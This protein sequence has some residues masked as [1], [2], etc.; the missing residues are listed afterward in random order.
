MTRLGRCILCDDQ[1]DPDQVYDV[2]LDSIR[3]TVTLDESSEQQLVQDTQARF[4][5]VQVFQAVTRSY[6]NTEVIGHVEQSEPLTMTVD[7]RQYTLLLDRLLFLGT[8]I[9]EAVRPFST[10]LFPTST[11]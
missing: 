5:V 3:L 7:T 6:A 1:M 2:K 10:P 4:R 11:R 8:T 9:G